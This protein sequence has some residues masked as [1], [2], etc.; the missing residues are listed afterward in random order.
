MRL[1]RRKQIQYIELPWSARASLG[2]DAVATAEAQKAN[3]LL[4]VERGG[5]RRRCIVESNDSFYVMSELIDHADVYFCAGYNRQFFQQRRVPDP[6]AW[7]GE[8]DYATYRRRGNELIVRHGANFDRVRPYIPIAPN[9][10]RTIPLPGWRQKLRNAKHK[11][12]SRRATMPWSAELGDFEQRYGQLLALRGLPCVHDIVLLD[13]L[14]GWPRHRVAL[15]EML[16]DLKIHGFKVSSRL[17][18]HQPSEWD[19]SASGPLMEEQFP[20]VTGGPVESYEQMLAQS[21]LAPFAAGFHY[22]WRNIMTMAL[23]VGIP[24]LT[25]R[26]ILEPWFGLEKFRIAF[27]DDGDWASLRANIEHTTDVIR[28]GISKHNTAA[29]DA[30]MTPEITA[31][32]VLETAL[33]ARS[34]D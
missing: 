30:Y 21:R 19:G 8:V 32:Y 9:L 24:V 34:T 5:E 16:A 15:H 11:L 12:D 2:F 3:S 27:N 28:A 31:R 7:Q 1:A 26:I 17:D 4:V 33:A 10:G 6:L 20:R 18:W 23:M 14:W 22:G 29:F 13:T 25:D